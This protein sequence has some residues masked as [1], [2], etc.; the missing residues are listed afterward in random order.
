MFSNGQTFLTPNGTILLSNQYQMQPMG[1]QPFLIQSSALPN[2]LTNQL[3]L[4]KSQGGNLY[5]QQ[6]GLINANSSDP[7]SHTVSNHH[8]TT[9]KTSSGQ[10]LIF[11][12]G[13]NNSAGAATGGQLKLQPIIQQAPTTQYLQ[14]STP[15]GPMLVPLM[16]STTATGA[17]G[18]ES[19]PT[20]L[21]TLST[22]AMGQQL[23]II[24]SNQNDALFTSN[25]HPGQFF[26]T[27]SSIGAGNTTT[28]TTSS[29]NNPMTNTLTSHSTGNTNSTAKSKPTRKRSASTYSLIAWQYF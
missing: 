22:G 26:I 9:L 13:Q 28:I 3:T 4:A 24:P 10:T 8:T 6:T 18:P 27:S 7:N 12:T 23:Q 16:S 11:P 21:Q 19:A 25:H 1:Q 17:G 29:I 14:I 2:Q 5:A 15:N 20:I